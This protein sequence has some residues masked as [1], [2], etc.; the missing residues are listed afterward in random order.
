MSIWNLQAVHDGL[1]TPPVFAPVVESFSSASMSSSTSESVPSGLA[2]GDIV[3]LLG[4]HEGTGSSAFGDTE[5]TPDWTTV[6]Q[7][8]SLAFT[9]YLGYQVQGATPITSINPG[10]WTASGSANGT[11]ILVRIS[12][13]TYVSGAAASITGSGSPTSPAVTTANDKSLVIIGAF[14]DLDTVTWSPPAG[15]TL[16]E[17]LAS[18]P[19]GYGSV[20]LAYK[21]VTTAGLETPGAWSG[22]AGSADSQ[23]FTVEIAPA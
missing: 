6:S 21:E 5:N 19:G 13:G 7:Q 10:D 15:Y 2:E 1:W 17:E 4:G 23:A 11:L 12:G 20:A 18:T 14:V 16:I 9:T 22:Y 3:L 8:Q